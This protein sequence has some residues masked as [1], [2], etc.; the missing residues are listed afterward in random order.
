MLAES[1][2]NPC[3]FVTI[4]RVVPCDCASHHDPG[5]RFAPENSNRDFGHL[6]PDFREKHRSRQGTGK[7]VSAAGDNF[8]SKRRYNFGKLRVLVAAC[9]IPGTAAV[10]AGRIVVAS[11]AARGT[12]A[13]A[14]RSPLNS[15]AR[16]TGIESHRLCTAGS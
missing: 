13:G 16:Y 2:R 12:D 5:P 6:F 8:S 7:S 9:S 3:G 11:T 1:A 4:T 14:V 15:L 10:A